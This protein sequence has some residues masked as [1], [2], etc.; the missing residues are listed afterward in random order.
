M[1]R[2]K[3]SEKLDVAM[4]PLVDGRQVMLPLQALAEVQQL[5]PVEE[6]QTAQDEIEWRG[7]T[8]DIESLDALLGL[9]EPARE[10]FTTVGIFKSGKNSD[11]PFRALAFYGTP[12]Q[13]RIES[14]NLSPLKSPKEECFVGATLLGEQS[15]L[16]PD[17]PR[18]L[19]K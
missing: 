13:G 5:E 9:T 11:K 3:E 1:A 15:Y 17:L 18:L 6:G 14:A 8:L 16:I 2:K 12:A 19:A 10:K 7:F 4:F